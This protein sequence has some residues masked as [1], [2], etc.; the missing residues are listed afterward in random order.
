MLFYAIVANAPALNIDRANRAAI[1]RY[2][3]IDT[4]GLWNTVAGSAQIVTG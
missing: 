2:A 3:D 1:V 4:A